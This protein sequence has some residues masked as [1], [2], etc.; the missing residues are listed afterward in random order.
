MLRNYFITAFRNLFREKGST[1]INVAGLTLG[2]TCSMVLFLLVR[3]LSSF[4][5]FHVNRERIYRVVTEADGNSGKFHTAGVPT[6]L[7]DAFKNDFPEA[8]EV[9][10]VSYRAGAQITIP[11]NDGKEPKKYNEDRGVTFAE[12]N[13]FKV[14]DRKILQGSAGMALDKPYEAIISASLA[15]KY[16]SSTDVIGRIV[17]HDTVE[18]KIEA[19]MA[20]APSNTDLPFDLMLSY[21]TI[22]KA[23]EANAWRGIWSDEQC[24]ILLRNGERA[25]AID[26][27][28]PAFVKKYL[29]DN[30]FSNQTFK[31]QPLA[32][33]HYDQDYSTL[34]YNTTSRG[35]LF[36]LTAV[37]I[38][39]IITACINFINLATAEAVKRS[40]EVGIRKTLGSSRLQ[41]MAQFLGETSMVTA[42]SMI[43]SITIAQ[44]ALASLNSFLDIQLQMDFTDRMLWFFIIGVTLI[45]SLLS[46][47][48]PSFVISGYRPAQALKNHINSK[49]SASFNLRRALVVLQFVISQGFIIGTIVLI[50]QMEYFQKKDLGFKKDAIVLVPIPEREV[51]ENGV[52]KM[53]TLRDELEKLP[54]VQK[55]SLSNSAPSSGTVSGTAF[56]FE[57]EDPNKRIDVQVKQV[58]GNYIDLFDLKMIGGDKLTDSDT[59]TGFVVNEQLIKVAGFKSPEEVLGKRIVMWGLTLPIVGVVKNFH[60]VSLE[61]AIEPTILMNRLRGYQNLSVQIDPTRFQTVID[62][63]KPKWEASY[64]EHIFNY[65]FLDEQ[66]REFYEGEQRMS[67]L[68]SIF[69]SIAIFIGCLGLLGLATFMANQRTKEIGVRKVLGAS[70]ES[71]VLLFTKEYVKLI[72]IGFVL[73]APLA[74]FIMNRWLDNFAYKINIGPV[75]FVAGLVITLLI[76][77]ITVGFKSLKAAIVNPAQSLKSE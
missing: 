55:A 56:Y 14:F 12:P 26:E 6:A 74:W 28:M 40:K 5:K 30:N 38:I 57:G 50:Q 16:F 41:L 20:D 15:K 23:R 34:S 76:A 64:S 51:R 32:E 31:L 68:L 63:I 70:V 21:A 13:F 61:T 43:L 17:K 73:A 19:V 65:Q 22:E 18:Y 72:F 25:A 54:G 33:M 1:V 47:L 24:Y 58:D 69:T 2:I 66:I 10:F 36:A 44:L 59:A 45:V 27:R 35:V 3:H 48:Y 75:I 67:V 39:L 53:K 60:T 71:I 7:P 52:S 37:A 46:G 8:E 9:T 11:T 42:A 77:L 4:D 49:S 29:G 62:A